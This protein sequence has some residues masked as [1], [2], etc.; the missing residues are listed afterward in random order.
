M[1][2]CLGYGIIKNPRLD[3]GKSSGRERGWKA[4]SSVR[5]TPKRRDRVTRTLW[6][7]FNEKRG[8][9]RSFAHLAIAFCRCVNIPARYCT[10]YLGDIGK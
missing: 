7:A 8:V 5:G 9:C 3:S 1:A 4:N 10:G 2:E 6:E